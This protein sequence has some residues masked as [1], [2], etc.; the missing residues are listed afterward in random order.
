MEVVGYLTYVLTLILTLVFSYWYLVLFGEKVGSPNIDPNLKRQITAQFQ[1]VVTQAVQVVVFPARI[2]WTQVTS[3]GQ[4]LLQNWK[5]V[6]FFTMTMVF[7]VLM[8][9]EHQDM[10][11]GIDQLWR[12]VGHTA[13]YDFFMPLL[14]TL[15]AIYGLLVPMYNLV[16][17]TFFQLWQGTLQILLKCQVNTIFT[18]VTHF[19]V[20]VVR[21]VT[22]FVDFLGFK[23]IP[24]DA[25]NNIAV[26]DFN[27]ESAM[28][29]FMQSVN[30]TQI[31]MR[32]A[33]DALDPAWDIMYAPV[34]SAH[35]PKAI[36]HAWNTAIRFVQ[37]FLR[38]AVPPHEVPNVERFTY[39][40]YGTILETAFFLDHVVYTTIV[41]IV[42][43]FSLSLFDEATLVTPKEFVFSSLARGGLTFV[44][45]P[46]NLFSAVMK[47][48]TPDT[49]GNS[50]AMMNAF[51][52]DDMW[53]NLHIANY[54]ISN[55]LHWCLYLVENIAGSIANGG[56][57]PSALPAEFKCDWVND[58]NSPTWSNAPHTISY[59]TACTLY[60]GGLVAIGLPLVVTELMK[61]LFF[62][63]IVLQEQN[64]W[65]VLQKYDGMWSSREEVNDCEARQRRAT[66]LNGTHR[67]DWTIS[68][69]SCNCNMKLGEYVAPDPNF[70]PRP[71]D[72]RYVSEPV[73]NPWCAQPTLQ[74]QVFAPMDAALIYATH[75]IFGPSGIGEILQYTKVPGID[76]VLN[77]KGKMVDVSIPSLPPT[78]RLMI[79]IMRVGVRLILSLPDMFDNQWVY[80][81]INCGYGLNSSQL[82][83]R[84]LILNGVVHIRGEYFKGSEEIWNTTSMAYDTVPTPYDFPVSDKEL[85]W[86]PCSLRRFL[87]P[88]IP[89]NKSYDMR[90]CETTN[91]DKHCSCNFMLNLTMD[92]PCAC[93]AT[94]PE[95]STVM[96]DNPIN[97]FLAYKKLTAASYRWCNSNYLEW[98]F[99][100]QEQ[101]LDSVAYMLSFA[102]W[103]KDCT[104]PRKVTADTNMDSYYVIARTTTTDIHDNDGLE[105]LRDGCNLKISD[106]MNADKNAALEAYL[107]PKCGDEYNVLLAAAAA[108]G[109]CK[110][111]GNY[112]L[113]CS[114]SMAWR[115]SGNMAVNVQRQVHSNIMQFLGGN[116]NKFDLDL[117][118]RICDLEKAFAAQISII[119]NL[120]T[121]GLSKGPLKKAMGKI[122]IAVFEYFNLHT[123]KVVNILAQFVLNFVDEIKKIATRQTKSG[124]DFK[125][126]LEH[127]IKQLVK[128]YLNLYM[129]L[130]ILFVDALGD[131]CDALKSGAGTPSTVW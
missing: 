124:A 63:S 52:M 76:F 28:A 15:R 50:A 45:I 99:F 59:T 111:W 41:N 80:N 74:D 44:Q 125:Q 19:V 51:N 84:Y 36:D 72:Y 123:V 128:S 70:Y 106:L 43:T 32:C 96:D 130:V 5:Y 107:A 92:S 26:N 2:A 81:D 89:Y 97:K 37:M 27:T 11:S 68:N 47:L 55:S 102:P 120:A 8:H 85:R 86:Q 22:G 90:V 61:E 101:M 29:S 67:M 126:G 116:F 57:K 103:N 56:A 49:I 53:A 23:D 16:V 121:M 77:A 38:I 66:P 33:C 88:G 87:F 24:L 83:N 4:L 58:L 13:F 119:T 109:T 20:G 127:N 48:F 71:D 31:G 69:T 35:L 82:D 7:C 100:M 14:Q 118:Y 93:I 1:L 122:G 117:K 114:L 25:G 78:T 9:Y 79:E 91:E 113:F 12:C 131:F 105:A 21:L 18:P 42:R 73:Y 110:L 10:M 108:K 129:D 34:T 95:L 115:Q 60:N 94:V 62:K 104:T 46:L 39:H 54:D 30:A 6:I 98:F 65:R 112:N 17:V 3:F 64:V 75:G 40:L